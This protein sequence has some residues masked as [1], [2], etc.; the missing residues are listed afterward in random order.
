M[1]IHRLFLPKY[2]PK[3]YDEVGINV[4]TV[5]LQG[6]RGRLPMPNT[7]TIKKDTRTQKRRNACNTA[8]SR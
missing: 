6:L 7:A 2:L 3:L 4:N 1:P 8:R 5:E